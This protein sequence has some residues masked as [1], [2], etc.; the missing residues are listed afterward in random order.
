MRLFSWDFDKLKCYPVITAD[1][2]RARV[3]ESPP[4]FVAEAAGAKNFIFV[5]Q[6]RATNA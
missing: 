5:A 1:H 3:C 2:K 6:A 4:P